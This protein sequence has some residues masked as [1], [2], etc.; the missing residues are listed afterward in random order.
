MF[1]IEPLNYKLSDLEPIIS[2][3]LMELHYNKHYQGYTNKLNKFAKEE[4]V[5]EQTIEQLLANIS[6]YSQNLINNAGGH[7]NHK[8]FW[9]C[10]TAPKSKQNQ[11][12][13]KMMSKIEQS[14]GS[15]DQFKT[16][17]TA[18]ASG[19]FGSGWL[20]LVE[21]EDGSLKLIQTFNQEAIGMD[22]IDQ[23]HGNNKLLLNLDVW[24]H[25]Y[26]LNYQNRRADYINNFFD[27]I[28]WDFVESNLK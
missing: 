20:N 1:K 11:I 12:S 25:A 21:T 5:S 9:Q 19:L 6:Q 7:Y 13:E 4:N 22:F 24:E 16:E 23:M 17:F 8:F 26:Y 28:N 15:F 27:I 10:L 18:A 3:D 14:F 2:K